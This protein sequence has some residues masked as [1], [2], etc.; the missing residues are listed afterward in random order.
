[1]ADNTK[2]TQIVHFRAASMPR[3][4]YT[5]TYGDLPIVISERYKYLG[6]ILT[7]FLD[8]HITASIIAKS[9]GTALGYIHTQGWKMYIAVSI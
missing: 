6:L 8:Y 9:A 4:N 3:S 7:E 5:F 2:K 1:M